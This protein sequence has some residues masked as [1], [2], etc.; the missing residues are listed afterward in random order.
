MKII[1][2]MKLYLQ[3]GWLSRPAYLFVI[4]SALMILPGLY[5]ATWQL[6]NVL[7]A[8]NRHMRAGDNIRW[9][10]SHGLGEVFSKYAYSFVISGALIIIGLQIMIFALV[11]IQNKFYFD[12]LY[13]LGQQIRKKPH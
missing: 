12:E 1:R 9:A 10:V 7:A 3:L 4:A 2:T 6:W 13:R 5:M 11:I 8:I